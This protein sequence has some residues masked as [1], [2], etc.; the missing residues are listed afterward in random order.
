[1][2]SKNESRGFPHSINLPGAWDGNQFANENDYIYH[3]SSSEIQ[4]LRDALSHFKGSVSNEIAV[5]V[6]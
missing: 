5:S 3:L 2:N 4:E 1:M 6:F